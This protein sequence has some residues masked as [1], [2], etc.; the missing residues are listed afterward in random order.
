MSIFMEGLTRKIRTFNI[1]V[2]S[3]LN[4]STMSFGQKYE[5]AFC[6]GKRLFYNLRRHSDCSMDVDFP[7]TRDITA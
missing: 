4:Y 3:I 2:Y 6:N 1:F 5:G 7:H